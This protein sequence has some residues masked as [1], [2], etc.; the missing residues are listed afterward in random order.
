MKI[1]KKDFVDETTETFCT[2]GHKLFSGTA[3]F[4]EESD[5]SIHYGGKRYAE[6]HGINDTRDVPDLT[7]W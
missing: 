1:L 2:K 5:E 4:M 3:Y 6:R 7:R